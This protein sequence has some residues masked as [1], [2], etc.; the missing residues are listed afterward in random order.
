MKALEKLQAEMH[1]RIVAKLESLSTNPRPPECVKI[2]VE[3]DQ[4]RV[5]VGDFRNRYRVNDESQVVEVLSIADRK[6]AYR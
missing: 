6:D 2:R 3:P 1:D 4:F 5:R